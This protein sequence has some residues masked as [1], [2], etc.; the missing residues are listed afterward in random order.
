MVHAPTEA[1]KRT[2]HTMKR[3]KVTFYFNSEN[4]ETAAGQVWRWEENSPPGICYTELRGPDG[5]YIDIEQPEKR[6]E[7]FDVELEAKGH[8]WGDRA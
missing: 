3:Y 8:G 4:D 7:E 6:C 2:N 5:R 1:N